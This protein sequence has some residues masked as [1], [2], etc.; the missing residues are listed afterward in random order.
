LISTA[1]RSHPAALRRFAIGGQPAQHIVRYSTQMPL[2][3]FPALT[4]GFPVSAP[5]AAKSGADALA[6]ASGKLFDSAVNRK[7][8]GT[9]TDLTH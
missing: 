1:R 3:S 6:D 7:V 8:D 4:W 9:F 2:R 5:F